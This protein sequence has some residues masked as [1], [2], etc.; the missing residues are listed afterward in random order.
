VEA[1][2]PARLSTAEL[3]RFG[4]LVG[5]AFATF[6][7]IAWWR[8]RHVTATVLAVPAVLLI[9]GGLV[10]PSRMGPVYRAWMRLALA[11][12]KVTTPIFMGVVYFLVITPLGVIRRAAGRN[13]LKRPDAGGTYWVTRPAGERRSSLERQ[14]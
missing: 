11:L 9:A 2:I 5:G 13:S 4:L 1:G 3:R 14:F 10:V 7:A 8:G 12:S 6:A